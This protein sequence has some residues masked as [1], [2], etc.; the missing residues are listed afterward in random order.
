MANSIRLPNFSVDTDAAVVS[1][2]G[3]LAEITVRNNN[4]AAQTTTIYDN[5]S[6]AAP[7]LVQVEVPANNTIHLLFA[8]GRGNPGRNFGTGLYFDVGSDST[9]TGRLA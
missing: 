3:W 8:G 5:S 2:G 9:V 7:I 1:G 4:A 6:A